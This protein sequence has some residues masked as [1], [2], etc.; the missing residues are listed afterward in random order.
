MKEIKELIQY[1]LDKHL[2]EE[3]DVTYCINQLLD[4]LGEQ[5]YIPYEG[6]V[7]HYE[8]PQEILDRMLAYLINKNRLDDGSVFKDLMDTRI[9]NVITPRPSMVRKA[10]QEAYKE[11][12]LAATTYYY[13]FSKATNYVRTKRIQKDRHWTCDTAYGKMDITINLSKPEKDPKAIAMAGSLPSSS[14]PS[15]LLCKEN[16]GYAGTLKHPARN[17]HRIIP[18]TLNNTTYHLQYSPYSYYNEHCI[19]FHDQHVP[20]KITKKTFA[21]LLDFVDFLPHYFIGSNTDI[22]IVGGSILSHDHFQGGN[23]IFAMEEAPILQTF[24]IAG[25]EDLQVGIVKWPLSVIRV[26]GSDQHKLSDFADYVLQ[27]WIQYNDCDRDIVS[28]TDTI[29]HNAITP[30]VR[31]RNGMYEMDLV[32]RNNRTNE[33]YPDGIFHPHAHLHHIKKENIGLIEVMGLAVLPQRLVDEMELMKSYLLQD[34]DKQLPEDLEKHIVWLHELIEKHP[35]LNEQNVD[36]ILE[37]EIGQVFTQVLEDAG[38]FKQTSDGLQG[39][40]QFMEYLSK[41]NT[42]VVL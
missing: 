2:I 42:Q 14:Y 38:V 37:D 17:N 22:P 28:H 7:A 9:M 18:L 21:S 10:F 34:G 33:Q 32:L 13:N 41:S 27:T 31:K 35:D 39:F 16:E 23:Y 25:Y 3:D 26:S 6:D 24:H 5:E 36:T 20:M 15:C 19:V 8:E 1:G 11:S 4:V 40:Q 12:P 29:R 30:I